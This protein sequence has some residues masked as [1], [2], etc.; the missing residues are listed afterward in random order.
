MVPRSEHA[1]SRVDVS[2]NA[3]KVL[4]RL[5]DAGYRAF[6]VGGSVRD[7]L[8]GRHPKDFD[9]ATDA[10]PEEVRAL[11]SNSRLIGRRFRLA[12]VR[13]G[14]EIIEVATFRRSGLQEDPDNG[15]V[16]H[17]SG[18]I[19]SDNV[20]GTIEEDAWRR[21]FTVNALYYNI[22]DNSI[23]AFADGL[24]DLRARQLRLIGD[25]E[26]RYRED[27]VRMLR[28]ARFAAKLGFDVHPDT[29]APIPAMAAL[30]D[31]VPSARLFDEFLKMFQTGH[32]LAS[33]RQLRKLGLFSHLFPATQ[34]WLGADAGA[35]SSANEMIE[36]A[37][38][39]TDQ[40][41]VERKPITPMFLFGVF[42]WLPVE[43]RAAELMASGNGYSEA[44]ALIAASSEVSSRQAQRIALPRRF[45]F[46]MQEMLQLQ[47]RFLKKKGR[48]AMNLLSHRR[49]RA[50]YDLMLLRASVGEIGADVAD[51]WTN[52]Q[53]LSASARRGEFGLKGR[54]HRPPRDTAPSH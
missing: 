20:Y 49:F 12:H 25:P 44:Q 33:Y 24:T 10:H 48:R 21:D 35:G 31:D 51:F 29:A 3:L 19:I 47:P 5:K 37:L 11:F 52:V 9:I 2:K 46:P 34:Q 17:A 18:R 4:Y 13:F 36:R 41:V 50:A 42:L 7:L 16:F 30:I 6:L 32:A 8:L 39:N 43:A 54:G 38:E 1:M 22:A 40:R 45:G 14:R 53:T 23:W 26:R 27:P 28:A 15:Q